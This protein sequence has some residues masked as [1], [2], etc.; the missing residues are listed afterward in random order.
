[1]RTC[2]GCGA[3]GQWLI[4]VHAQA[5]DYIFCGQD[6]FDEYYYKEVAASLQGK[7]PLYLD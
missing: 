7:D 1:M 5:C 6:C 2:S 3:R 4:V